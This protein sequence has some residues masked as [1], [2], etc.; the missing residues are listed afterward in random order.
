MILFQKVCHS[1]ENFIAKFCHKMDIE[2]L[3]LGENL[4]SLLHDL[5]IKKSSKPFEF[6]K[7]EGCTGILINTF[8]EK[9]RVILKIGLF[10]IS[11]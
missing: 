6:R 3:F 9:L 11:L 8:S 2:L 10:V 1:I 4:K 5:A 7:M